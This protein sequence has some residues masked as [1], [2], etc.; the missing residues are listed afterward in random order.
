M[1]IP[2]IHTYKLLVEGNDDQHVV[3][4][5][6]EKHNV[7]ETFDVVDCESVKNVLK[8]FEVRL[9]LADNNSRIGVVMDADINLKSRWDSFVSILK[10]TGKYDCGAL[11][12]PKDG[13]VLEPTDKTYP[14]VGVW[15]MPDNNQ[16]GMLEDFMAALATPDDELMKKS[17]AMLTELETEG[18]QK[19]KPVHRSKAKIHTYLAWQDV[20][21]RPMG[22]AITANILNSDSEV[23]V[24]FVKWLRKMF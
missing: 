24:R 14:K 4:A 22:Q 13:L 12:L 9:R 15:L 18:I 1:K 10:R 20:P 16:N 17:D 8:S 11:T 21:G 3:W 2:E 7:P 5:L 19:Y 6:C 23:A